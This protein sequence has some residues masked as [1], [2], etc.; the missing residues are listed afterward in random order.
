[1]AEIYS[2][3]VDPVAGVRADGNATAPPQPSQLL[4]PLP[5]H[6]V[7]QRR[8]PSK[9]STQSYLTTLHLSLIDLCKSAFIKKHSTHH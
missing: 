4:S 1:M 2:T 5:V 6:G 8:L 9:K 3:D 7:T